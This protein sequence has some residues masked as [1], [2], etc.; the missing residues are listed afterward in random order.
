MKFLTRRLSV[1]NNM[2]Y[3]DLLKARDVDTWEEAATITVAALFSY[4]KNYSDLYDSNQL[5]FFETPLSTDDLG[6][7]KNI[8]N[9]MIDNKIW[10]SDPEYFV[11]E[12]F[13]LKRKNE[14]YHLKHWITLSLMSASM[15][16]KLKT[17]DYD[18]YSFFV[19][20][21]VI[22]KQKDYGPKNI[23]RFGI[24]GLVIRTH[25][26]V[27]RL[28]NLMLKNNTPQNESLMDTLLDVIGYSVIAMMWINHTFLF[29]LSSEANNRHPVTSIDI[30]IKNIKIANGVVDATYPNIIFK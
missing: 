27:A 2:L 11:S 18:D 7:M 10:D 17:F 19:K 28:E 20:K 26:K 15:I 12:N 9:S 1:Q 24:N 5:H 14:I 8:I 16:R 3:Q 25:D 13:D 23:S 30:S 22:A 6:N 4:I 29:D 21:T